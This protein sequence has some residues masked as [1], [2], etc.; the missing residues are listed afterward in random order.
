LSAD[1]VL[2]GLVAESQKIR[3]GNG[4]AKVHLGPL[5]SEIQ[6]E[7]VTGYI[8]SG[9]EAGAEIVTGG[10][11]LGGELANGYFLPPTVFTHQDDALKIVKEEIFGPV[12]AVTA[13][14][15]WD[16]WSSVRTTPATDWRRESGRRTSAKPTVSRTRS[17]PG[18]CGSTATG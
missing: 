14:D 12:V 9:R 8:A 7:R 5:V 4:F 1:Q 17:R 6:L 10:E 16:D 18:R 15:D 2:D 3:V 11:R 13:F